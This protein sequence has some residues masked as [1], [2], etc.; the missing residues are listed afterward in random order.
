LTCAANASSAG[1][2]TAKHKKNV[3]KRTETPN[4]GFLTALLLIF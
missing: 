4:R 1:T 2:K 3:A